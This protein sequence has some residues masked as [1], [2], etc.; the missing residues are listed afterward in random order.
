MIKEGADSSTGTTVKP[1]TK[2]G[3]QEKKLAEVGDTKDTGDDKAF[4]KQEKALISAN[5]KNGYEGV[6]EEIESYAPYE[7]MGSQPIRVPAANSKSASPTADE[8]KSELVTVGAM[9]LVTIVSGL[10]VAISFNA[11]CGAGDNA[12]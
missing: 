3:Q 5:Q 12:N 1:A 7:D 4:Q 8:S 6:M 9:Q 11:V 2:G 10:F